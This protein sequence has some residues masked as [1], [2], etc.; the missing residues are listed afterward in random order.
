[1]TAAALE[2]SRIL[3]ESDDEL[4][5]NIRAAMRRGRAEA[6]HQHDLR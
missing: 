1:M 6:S 4:A 3:E 2:A 5:Q